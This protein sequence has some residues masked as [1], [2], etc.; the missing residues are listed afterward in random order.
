MDGWV[1]CAGEHSARNR[2]EVNELLHGS[3]LHLS[4]CMVISP[5]S[6]VMGHSCESVCKH[7]CV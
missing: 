4:L 7:L 5:L 3:I 2:A 6:A 1:I